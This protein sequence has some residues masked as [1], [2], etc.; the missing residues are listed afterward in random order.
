MA[1]AD[2]DW[3]NWPYNLR[4]ARCEFVGYK[5]E[6]EYKSSTPVVKY[7]DKYDYRQPGMSVSR[8]HLRIQLLAIGTKD[9]FQNLL[10]VIESL[11]MPYPLLICLLA[12]SNHQP[13]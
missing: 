13:D 9:H 6:D 3:E 5:K 7:R 2:L 4:E 1:F 8:K 12:R 10:T 11:W